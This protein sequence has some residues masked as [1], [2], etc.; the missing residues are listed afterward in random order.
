MIDI[1]FPGLAVLSHMGLGTEQI[2]P[3]D[4]TDMLR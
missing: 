1:G 4:L 3:V 2:G